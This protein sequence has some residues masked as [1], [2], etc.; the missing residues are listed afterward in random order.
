MRILSVLLLCGAAIVGAIFIVAVAVTILIGMVGYQSHGSGETIL[1]ISV[2]VV[3]FATV[4][5]LLAWR[6]LGR[7]P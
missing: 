3:A 7:K 4:L 1:L 6:S 2:V 5:L